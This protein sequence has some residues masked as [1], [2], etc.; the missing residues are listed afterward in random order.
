[1]VNMDAEDPKDS[2]KVLKKNIFWQYL[3]QIAI[4]VFPFITL[5]YLTRVL[6]PD[7]YAVRAYSISVI[8]LFVTFID[9]GCTAYGTREIARHRGDRELVRKI[10]STIFL[11]RLVLAAVGAGILFAVMPAVPVMAAN[12]EYMLIAYFGAVLTAMLPDFVFQ[13]LEDMSILTKR[14]VVSRLVSLV[15]IFTFIKGPDQLV[16]VAVFEAVPALIAF[17]WSWIEVVMKRK[18]TLS[19]KLLELKESLSVLK[20]SAVFFLSSASTTIFTNLTTVMIGIYIVNQADIS[21]WSIAAMCISMV[22]SLYNPIYNSVYPHVVARRDF[23]IIKKFL[24]LGTPVVVVGSIALVFLSPF[25]MWVLGGPEYLDGSI[26]L[27]LLTPVLIFSYPTV[28]IGY[29]ILAVLNKEKL[30]TTASV[31]AALF[32]IAGLVILALTGNFTIVNVALLRCATEL[33]ML[34][35]RIV[36]VYRCRDLMAASKQEIERLARQEHQQ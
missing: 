31:S 20:T 13:G 5:P 28:L 15:L 8:N 23:S 6:G 29:P 3:L 21:Y 34:A 4:Y 2:K 36:F 14:F 32:H 17:V 24:I 35:L 30:L 33:V 7:E 26:V 16:L 19:I 12:P 27:Q 22:Q 25:V 9:F 10:T 1:M 11:Q 18:I